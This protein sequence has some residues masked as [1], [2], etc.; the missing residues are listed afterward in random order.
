MFRFKTIK[1]TTF[2][3]CKINMLQDQF[4]STNCKCSSVYLF[5]YFLVID[6][7]IFLRFTWV[8][9]SQEVCWLK[10]IVSFL[11]ELTTV[12]NFLSGTLKTLFCGRHV[13]LVKHV[14]INL[15]ILVNWNHLIMQ[16][17]DLIPYL[18]VYL[19]VSWK[20]PHCEFSDL[21]V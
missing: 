13:Y 12:T 8:I 7:Y 6:A 5:Y 21:R 18:F 16:T 1:L 20:T 2:I 10:F 19:T 14:E 17:N 9:I 3:T 15:P 4:I 11:E